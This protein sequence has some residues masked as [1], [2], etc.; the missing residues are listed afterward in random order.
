MALSKFSLTEPIEV[1]RTAIW[2]TGMYVSCSQRDGAQTIRI[3]LKT[4]SLVDA[5]SG[6]VC[7]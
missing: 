6:N 3:D 4:A 1:L 7:F 2:L 5:E